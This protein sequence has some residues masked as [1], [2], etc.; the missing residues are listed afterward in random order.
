M[1][2]FL[3]LFGHEPDVD[4]LVP[5]A[6]KCLEKGDA[7][8][9]V[10]DKA[11]PHR[12]DARFQFLGRYPRFEIRRLP[13][14]ESRTYRLSVASQLLWPRARVRSL[15]RRL[16]ITACFFGWGTGL[17]LR[18]GS[19]RDALRRP[20]RRACIGAALDL[21]LPVFALPN[22]VDFVA[23]ADESLEG[24]PRA[25]A[26]KEIVPRTDRDC[27]SAYVV[28]TER[29]REW[30]VRRY[31]Q[32]PAVVQNW[33]SLRFC[34]EWRRILLEIAPRVTLPPRPPGQSRVLFFLPK[35]KRFVDQ[36]Q[37]VQVVRELAERE[38][39]Q[40]VIKTH[41]DRG[42]AQLASPLGKDLA[43]R[44]NVVLAGDASSPR[45]IEATDLTVL[46]YSSI[47]IEVL[48]QRKP[49]IDAAY[50]HPHQSTDYP[51][52]GSRIAQGA[53]DVHAL[54]DRVTRGEP[55]AVDDA[56]FDA[57]GRDVVYGGRE[58]FDV[59]E[60]YYARIREYV[61]RSRRR[62]DRDAVD[63]SRAGQGH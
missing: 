27:F 34:P 58:P 4:H 18:G 60:Y 21:N 47:A 57:V 63:S 39:V 42:M 12:T 11:L 32:D 24:R 5:L 61:G 8:V 31:G 62:V 35:W 43:A 25:A 37:T 46:V 22:G 29:N 50:L 59:P 54:V 52:H 23:P 16:E 20:L 51:Y 48:L 2:R 56:A 15:L 53:A 7:V 3:F 28:N 44:P 45:L 30:A 40:L 13:G 6:W 1:S 26:P 9:A 55:W 14:V 36:P 33:G 19:F 10:F 17:S 38:D 41:P 49:L